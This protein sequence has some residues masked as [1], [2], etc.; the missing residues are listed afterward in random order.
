MDQAPGGDVLIGEER[1]AI[2]AIAEGDA[3]APGRLP[4]VLQEAA[5][6]LLRVTGAAVGA[7]GEE[8]PVGGRVAE[9]GAEVETVAAEELVLETGAGRGVDHVGADAGDER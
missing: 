7:R 9:T 6:M 1:M 5:E 3:H 8:A 2:D 4:L